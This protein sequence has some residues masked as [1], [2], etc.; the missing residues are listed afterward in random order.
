LKVK[1]QSSAGAKAAHHK[2]RHL[3]EVLVIKSISCSRANNA[4]LVSAARRMLDHFFHTA[5]L[6]KCGIG[7]DQKIMTPKLT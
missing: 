5:P 7:D 4:K 3:A 2:D 6:E 1:W